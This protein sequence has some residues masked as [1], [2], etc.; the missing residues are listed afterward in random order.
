MKDAQ[1]KKHLTISLV[2]IDYQSYL[3]G[4]LGIDLLYTQAGGLA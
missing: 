1:K 4:T 2:S 3:D